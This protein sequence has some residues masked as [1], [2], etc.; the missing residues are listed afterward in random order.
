MT[1]PVGLLFLARADILLA[2]LAG[3]LRLYFVQWLRLK[4]CLIDRLLC[5]RKN[6]EF[7]AGDHIA[8]YSNGTALSRSQ[9]LQ[10]TNILILIWDLCLATRW[11]ELQRMDLAQHLVL[12]CQ[13]LTAEGLLDKL[14][15]RPEW[16]SE[17]VQLVAPAMLQSLAPSRDRQCQV[18]APYSMKC[19]P[20]QI[21]PWSGLRKK[22][23]SYWHS[24]WNCEALLGQQC[25][26]QDWDFI[27]P[28]MVMEHRPSDKTLCPRS[29]RNSMNAACSSLCSFSGIFFAVTTSRHLQASY[30]TGHKQHNLNQMKLCLPEQKSQ[31]TNLSRCTIWTEIS[32]SF[33]RCSA[34]C[35]NRRPEVPV[36]LSR[37][38]C[39][40]SFW[41]RLLCLQRRNRWRGSYMILCCLQKLMPGTGNC[42]RRVLMHIG[43]PPSR[44]TRQGGVHF[45]GM[46]DFPCFLPWQC[47]VDK[48]CL[49]QWFKAR[50]LCWWMCVCVC[51]LLVVWNR[52][53][54]VQR[55]RCSEIPARKRNL[56]TSLAVLLSWGLCARP[57]SA[58]MP[59][60]DWILLAL[61]V[62]TM[63]VLA[64]RMQG[65][66]SLRRFLSIPV[67]KQAVTS[68]LV[69]SASICKRQK[70]NSST[71][72]CKI[73]SFSGP[74]AGGG[75][76]RSASPGKGLQR[77]FAITVIMCFAR[78]TTGVRVVGVTMAST[79][80]TES[81]LLNSHTN[82]VAKQHGSPNMGSSFSSI[83]KRS[84]K[85]ACRRAAR[86]GGAWYRGHGSQMGN[87]QG[88]KTHLPLKENSILSSASN[89]EVADCM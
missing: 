34:V 6:Q 75:S 42:T 54:F 82:A 88:R 9:M 85:R 86:Q 74:K 58:H 11:V 22:L 14:R 32:Y 49:P 7:P 67:T 3:F 66:F 62:M 69:S 24:S 13:A 84:F 47:R 53:G 16:A 1:V 60:V 19:L 68:G 81:A 18:T 45:H 59:N 56:M 78:P 8:S 71:P 15:P 2:T 33:F 38:A 51:K 77:L 50:T 76:V 39:G 72:I 26:T 23:I 87:S 55:K 48:Y 89:K 5:D 25:V 79:G 10:W 17:S 44:E 83:R 12:N 35:W 29:S 4:E 61:H 65:S 31:T 52:M 30:M 80:V 70:R 37:G 36:H 27:S 46:F 28:H 73:V 41:S 43:C 57:G 20:V 21:S 64:C 63:L 40:L